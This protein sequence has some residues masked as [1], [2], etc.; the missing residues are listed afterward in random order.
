MIINSSFKNILSGD[1][2][3]FIN[4]YSQ[5]NNIFINQSYF[6]DVKS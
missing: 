1:S 2:G 5:K 4:I 3:G 6:N